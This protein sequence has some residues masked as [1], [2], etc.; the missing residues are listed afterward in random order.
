MDNELNKSKKNEPILEPIKNH[1]EYDN[2]NGY[3]NGNNF[4]NPYM[5]S[6]Q[7]SGASADVLNLVKFIRKI[8]PLIV[9]FFIMGTIILI[10]GLA[11]YTAIIEDRKYL[12]N[13]F[14]EFSQGPNPGVIWIAFSSIFFIAM[15]FLEIFLIIKISSFKNE[16]NQIGNLK[17][18]KILLIIGLIIPIFSVIECFILY[19]KSSKILGYSGLKT[20]A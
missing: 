3:Y 15:F 19:Y 5:M 7:N 2:R 6:N 11:T 9:L 8:C 18:G 14:Y 16:N 1:V 12:E 4:N 10:V 13:N 20:L 17:L